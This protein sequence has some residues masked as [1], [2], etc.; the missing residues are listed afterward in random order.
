MIRVLLIYAAALTAFIVAGT[1]ITNTPLEA[2]AWLVLLVEVVPLATWAGAMLIRRTMRKARA[3]WQHI[4]CDP[5]S[6]LP[7]TRAVGEIVAPQQTKEIEHVTVHQPRISSTP[8]GL[9]SAPSNHRE[10]RAAD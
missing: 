1:V 7:V 6:R 5:A 10:R 4:G 8:V 9:L 3:D 2:V